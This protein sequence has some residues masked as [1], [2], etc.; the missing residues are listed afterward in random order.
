MSDDPRETRK[1][2]RNWREYL[3][4]TRESLRVFGWV[5]RELIDETAKKWAR[6]L[7]LAALLS[8]VFAMAQPWLVRWIF[9]GLTARDWRLAAGGLAG[10]FACMLLSRLFGHLSWAGREH[11]LAASIVR[12][13]S[14]TTELFMAKSLGQHLRDNNALSV[15]NMEKGRSRVTWIQEMLLYQGVQ[16]IFDLAI[17][18]VFLWF[19]SRVVGAV[20]TGL[21]IN[22]LVWAVFLNRRCMEACTPI[23]AEFR[24]ANRFRVERWDKIERVKTCGKE[25]EEVA[26]LQGWLQRVFGADLRFWLW[27][28]KATSVRGLIAD[29][30]FLAIAVYGAWLV[31]QGNW[32]VGLLFPLFS[33]SRQFIDNLWRIG[34]IEHQMNSALP[35]VKSM[36]EALTLE[37]EIRDRDDA[38]AL[39]A[40]AV[41]RVEFS[42]VVHSYAAACLEERGTPVNGAARPVLQSVSFSIESGEKVALIGSSGAGKTTIMRLLQRYMD[43]EQGQVL[44]DGRDLRGYRLA[45][46]T[47]AL[48]YIAQQPQVLDGTIRSNLLYGLSAAEQAQVTD[49]DLWEV[50]HRLQIDFG[51]RLV[52]GLDTKVGR[53][54]I[55]LSGGEAQRLMIGAA[56]MRRPRFMV[57]DEAT[58]SLD[59]TTEKAVQFGLA[60]VLNRD[61]SA[62]IIAH[63]LSTVRHLCTKFVVLKSSDELAPGDVQVEAVAG[64]FEELYRVSPTFRQLADD[65]GVGV[66]PS[67][68]V[69]VYV[70]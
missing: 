57:I 60:E 45:S 54:G 61:M 49:D 37:P 34:Q 40:E 30:S 6:R 4:E 70:P 62:L 59:S 41:P 1:I 11:M 2:A 65:Q 31:W 50:M 9:D 27:F 8:T 26:H 51:D 16:A 29:L 28:I 67:R 25:A 33:W 23:D 46:W 47:A 39:P 21:L 68:A 35:S 58:S 10:F 64:S 14:R 63:R 55:K 38:V 7:L 44:V 20:M 24:R 12:V 5:W 19:L 42:G 17:T 66:A 53:N 69:N 13:D 52:D 32:T 18:F 48:G 36:M 43:P 15:A 56:A 3:S 22:Y